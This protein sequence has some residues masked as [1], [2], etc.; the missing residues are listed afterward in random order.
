ML[1][2]FPHDNFCDL[3]FYRMIAEYPP[4]DLYPFGTL[5]QEPVIRSFSTCFKMYS[6]GYLAEFSYKKGHIIITSM[7]LTQNLPEAGYLLSQIIQYLGNTYLPPENSIDEDIIDWL[8]EES[9]TGPDV[10]G[11]LKV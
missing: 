9:I 4:I 5:K 2:D 7:N 6:L 3:Q 8:I 10:F 1:G 11:S